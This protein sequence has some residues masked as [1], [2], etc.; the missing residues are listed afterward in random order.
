MIASAEGGQSKSEQPNQYLINAITDTVRAQAMAAEVYANMDEEDTGTANPRTE[1]DS[2]ANMTVL[3][4][5]AFVFESTG[6]ACNVHP[7]SAELGIAENVPIVDG[8][9]A[10]ESPFTGEAYILLVRNALHSF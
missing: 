6:R 10:Y 9:I 1:L 8:A 3:G 5:H 2:H 7:F 4:K